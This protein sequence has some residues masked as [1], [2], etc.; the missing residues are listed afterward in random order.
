LV[1]VIA[2]P[3]LSK[4]EKWSPRL[5][6]IKRKLRTLG[7]F[8]LKIVPIAKHFSES[9]NDDRYIAANREQRPSIRISEV[10]DAA[11]YLR[12]AL[13]LNYPNA[14]A[15]VEHSGNT[16]VFRSQI[17]LSVLERDAI[18]KL[19]KLIP[20]PLLFKPPRQARPVTFT[21]KSIKRLINALAPAY[22]YINTSAN[23]ES[24]AIR[25]KIAGNS[26]RLDL[27]S[28]KLTP[29]LEEIR[30]T[31]TEIE[32]VTQ[33][34]PQEIADWL[35]NKSSKVA[36][37]LANTLSPDG[38]ID[39]PKA[40]RERA[41]SKAHRRQ[42]QATLN[43]HNLKLRHD[44]KPFAID[45]EQTRMREGAISIQVVHGTLKIAT[46]FFN[47]ALLFDQFSTD[48]IV[49]LRR[50]LAFYDHKDFTSRLN[51]KFGGLGF[52]KR[53]FSPSVTT[54]YSIP[55]SALDDLE[56]VQR[57][58]SEPNI[59]LDMI[60]LDRADYFTN[61]PSKECGYPAAKH[62][63]EQE[64]IYLLARSFLCQQDQYGVT[65]HLNLTIQH[66]DS[67]L[68]T[69]SNLAL[70][71]FVTSSGAQLLYTHSPDNEKNNTS[72]RAIVEAT[73]Q[74]LRDRGISTRQIATE[75]EDLYQ[76]PA[77][78]SKLI[79]LQRHAA[80]LVDTRFPL[81]PGLTLHSH[82]PDLFSGHHGYAR[83]N[84]PQRSAD[85]L[86]NQNQLNAVLGH[87]S[88]Y[89]RGEM[90]EF[91]NFV[92]KAIY[93]KQKRL[94]EESL[95]MVLERLS[96][97]EGAP[98][99]IRIE[100]IDQDTHGEVRIT[101]QMNILSDYRCVLICSDKVRRTITQGQTLWARPRGFSIRDNAIIFEL[102]QASE[103]TQSARVDDL[104]SEANTRFDS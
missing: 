80:G 10:A 87:N 8:N 59:S 27:F 17:K 11:E 76:N 48:R 37:K 94:E 79:A 6:V 70:S 60:K 45:S 31:N 78:L 95:I 9:S 40:E 38:I 14:W 36:T 88:P 54:T 43:P 20:V 21:S 74:Y 1:V 55:L 68:I 91:R 63:N 77:L 83:F 84:T 56:Q 98:V 25:L 2:H 32:L 28:S 42:N 44:I 29:L 52:S 5:A 15:E 64:L 46:H 16:I 71:R 102:D 82:K 65:D 30:K 24:G 18:A 13:K 96:N 101:P 93:S 19:M 73:M 72:L 61:Y 103:A 66:I 81:S 4:I 3:R 104:E 67:L 53:S 51:S 85:A 62:R 12:D 41:F 7:S 22:V 26:E 100:Q 97:L 39:I 58:L 75:I 47:A 90:L 34:I 69:L 49:A 23:E 86:A 99:S 33:P 92:S 89:C 50:A 35:S 57:Y